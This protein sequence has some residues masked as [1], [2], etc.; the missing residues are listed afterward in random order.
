MA[1]IV[2]T[3]LKSL[4]HVGGKRCFLRLHRAPIVPQITPLPRRDTLL[5][6]EV[7]FVGVTAASKGGFVDNIGGGASDGVDVGSRCVKGD[8]SEVCLAFFLAVDIA[9][10]RPGRLRPKV[11]NDLAGT[12]L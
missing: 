6:A 12:G 7:A 10:Q 8:Q 9:A 4:E 3:R 2:Y 1:S 11:D 5:G